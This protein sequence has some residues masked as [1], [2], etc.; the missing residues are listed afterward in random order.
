MQRALIAGVAV[1]VFAPMIGTFLVQKR[2]SLIGDG[3]GHVAFAGVGRRV[4]WL[5]GLADVDGAACSRSAGSL[6]VEW[7]R[8]RRRASGDL[9][10]ALFFYSGIALGVVL[11]SLGGGLNA[12]VLTYLFGQPL[13]VNAQEVVRDRGAGLGHR[14]GDAGAATRAV[15]GGHR[16]GVVA[17]RRACRSGC[18]NTVLA[19]ITAV[20]VVAAMQIVG[21]LLIAAMMVLPVASGQL[22]ARSFAGTMRWAV[23]DRRRLG[24]GRSGGFA[25]SGTS[26]RAARSCCVAAGV[27]MVVAL[28]TRRV[29]GRVPMIEPYA[30]DEPSAPSHEGAHAG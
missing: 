17:R 15:R 22:L 11:V 12:S 28:V 3:I 9:A 18:V 20:A 21:I 10:L 4:C 1:G 7:L 27:F 13:T 19:V 23:A 29:G 25:R 26:R 14:G 30:P 16:R 8:S 2:M 5:G 24:G 6:G